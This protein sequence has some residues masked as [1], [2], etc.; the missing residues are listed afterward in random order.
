MAYICFGENNSNHMSIGRGNTVQQAILDWS[1]EDTELACFAEFEE[2][3]P[4]V[5]DIAT[6]DVKI[7]F[8]VTCAATV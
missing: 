8:N 7:T 5:A 1:S 3:K 6:V 2:Y 4:E